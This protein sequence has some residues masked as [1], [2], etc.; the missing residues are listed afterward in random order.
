MKTL[1]SRLHLPWATPIMFLMA[2]LPF[3]GLPL[4]HSQATDGV[5]QESGWQVEVIS[6]DTNGVLTATTAGGTRLGFI[7][8]TPI[9]GDSDTFLILQIKATR[10]SGQDSLRFTIEDT[11]VEGQNGRK[12]PMKGMV[13]ANGNYDPYIIKTTYQD[14]TTL[15]F[16][17]V[18]ADSQFMLVPTEG[19]SP[20]VVHPIR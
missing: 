16:P 18:G 12:F 13:Y 7:A 14:I 3:Y 10:T 8:S 4:A 20:V 5:L 9:F 11:Y 15:V 2:F 6:A 1:P 19:F 17:V